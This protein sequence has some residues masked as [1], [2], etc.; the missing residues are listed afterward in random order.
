MLCPFCEAQLKSGSKQCPDCGMPL[1]G[2]QASS[3][4]YPVGLIGWSEN[5]KHTT[6]LKKI[7]A[8]KKA[9]KLWCF[10]LMLIFIV[11]FGIAGATLNE[12]S[13]EEALIIGIGLALLM[14]IITL[15]RLSG[16]KKPVW[17]GAVTKKTAKRKYESG[18]DDENTRDHME[19]IVYITGTNGGKRKLRTRDNHAWYDYLNI[20][21]RVRYHPNLSFYEKYDKSGYEYLFCS[22]CGKQCSINED[23]C[24]FCG[25]P[26]FKGCV[27]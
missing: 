8:Q 6:V 20:G 12:M 24:H 2:P 22:L 3:S 15:V 25:T 17:E 10:I 7:T 13:M 14:L 27:K 26:L 9:A 23:V 16:M 1:S 4:T 21:D 5:Y 18:R 11:G 19:Y